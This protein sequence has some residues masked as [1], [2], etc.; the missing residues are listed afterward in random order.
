VVNIL[1]SPSQLNTWTDASPDG[2]SGGFTSYSYTQPFYQAG[3]VPV[4]LS[5]RNAAIF[6]PVPLRVVPDISADADPGT[7]FRIGLHQ[8]LPNGT[9]TYTETRYGGT[10]LASPLLAGIVAEAGLPRPRGVL[11][12]HEQLR[13]PTGDPVGHAGL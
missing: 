3:I 5:E 1:C 7:G 6:G 2:G 12:R 9:S 8:T 10:S 4:P 11:R 13:E